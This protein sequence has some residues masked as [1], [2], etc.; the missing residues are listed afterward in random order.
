M[1]TILPILLILLPIFLFRIWC[2]TTNS[3]EL[4]KEQ[5]YY[6]NITESSI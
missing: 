5:Y 6:C 4:S 3:E 2:K 1:L